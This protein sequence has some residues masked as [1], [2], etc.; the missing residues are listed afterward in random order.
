MYTLHKCALWYICLHFPEQMLTQVNMDNIP[1]P[2]DDPVELDPVRR[3]RVRPRTH[4]SVLQ[5]RRQTDRTSATSAQR[6]TII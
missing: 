4:D 3:T 2:T 6:T 5:G 1:Q